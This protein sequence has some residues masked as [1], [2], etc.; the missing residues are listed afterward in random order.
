MRKGITYIYETYMNNSFAII[1][2]QHIKHLRRHVEVYE[3]S[4]DVLDNMMWSSGHNILIHP[5]TYRLLGWDGYLRERGKK[6]LERLRLIKRRL[7][8]FDIAETSRISDEAVR[9]L[10]KMDLVF[11]PSSFSKE[12]MQ[13]CG[14]KAPVEVMPHGVHELYEL[15]KFCGKPLSR[16]IAFLKAMKEQRNYKYVLF[17]VWYSEHRKGGDIVADAMSRIQKEFDDVILLVKAGDVIDG[18]IHYFSPLRMVMVRGI[19]KDYEVVQ[20]YDLADVCV[21]PSRGG[22]FELNALEAMCRGVPTIATDGICFR[23]LRGY[24]IPIRCTNGH[25]IY[26]PQAIIHIGE[27]VEPDR[28]DFYKKLVDVLDRL[29]HYKREFERRRKELLEKYSWRRLC[30][31]ILVPKL[32]EFGFI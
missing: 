2:R 6:R 4:D 5:I 27:G 11:V 32:R 24:Y 16:K 28:E 12:I 26:P 30:D 18:S 17:F 20:L 13:K 14:V 25:R 8:G 9:I 21:V 1:S 23:D 31:E 22:A 7:G 3:V 10:N 19:L 15:Q 29:E